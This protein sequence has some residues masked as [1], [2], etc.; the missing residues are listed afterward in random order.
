MLR[1]LAA[2]MPPA[3]LEDL[4]LLQIGAKVHV[5]VEALKKLKAIVILFFIVCFPLVF[6]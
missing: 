2:L 6:L 5:L 4:R 1:H 3:E